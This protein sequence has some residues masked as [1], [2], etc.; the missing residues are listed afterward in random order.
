MRRCSAEC[1]S[2]LKSSAGVSRPQGND[3]SG[4]RE[5]RLT[6]S[7]FYRATIMRPPNIRGEDKRSIRQDG[8]SATIP[9]K[10]VL[11]S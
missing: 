10:I 1:G 11:A 5:I 7:V 3:I 2:V 4:Q 8:N 6:R 9:P